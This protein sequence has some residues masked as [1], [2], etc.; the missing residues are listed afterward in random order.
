[1]F[2]TQEQQSIAA[3]AR[4]F[5]ESEIRPIVKDLERDKAVLK[6]VWQKMGPL[7]LTGIQFPEQ[8]GGMG[9]DFVSYLLVIEELAKV[10]A[11]VAVTLS[12]HT[13]VGIYPILLFGSPQQHAQYL[14]GLISGAQMAAFGLTEP[15]AGSD[16]ANGLTRA[17]LQG[18]TYVINGS[19]IFITNAHLADVFVMTARSRKDVTGAK[20]L[21]A[22]I[23]EANTPGLHVEPG[24]E[25]LGL[26]GS[27]WG[28]L[29]FVD[30]KIP[31]S[32]R[33]GADG[34]GFKIF[35]SSL[36]AGR[37]S[38]GAMA[39]GIAEAA[40]ADSL[41]YAKERKQFGQALASFQA[42]Q[43]KLADMATEAAAAR[44]LVYHAGQLKDGGCAYTQEASMAKLY[45]SETAMRAADAA[46]QIHGGY[47][48]TKDF[49]VERYFRD[50]KSTELVEGTSQ[51][52]RLV[53]ARS[54]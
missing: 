49:D 24:D 16:A 51:V 37:I 9:L 5:A 3:L 2:L 29:A 10:S 40:L 17:E 18:E 45:A 21:S 22:F 30:L 39:L 36:D 43:F 25:K 33:L 42:I 28:N 54:L 34:E 7:G 23:V 35:M 50:A 4:E 32:Q 14:P 11:S 31:V 41:Q 46:V 1:M 48:Y 19:K 8:W 20:G 6:A 27:D 52:Q 38:I 26:H 47:G 15:N 53:I 44:H 13:T 12:V